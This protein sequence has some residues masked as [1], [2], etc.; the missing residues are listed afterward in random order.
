MGEARRRKLAGTSGLRPDTRRYIWG[1]GRGMR[2][3]IIVPIEPRGGNSF[4]LADYGEFREL[5]G[6]VGLDHGRYCFTLRTSQQQSEIA[7]IVLRAMQN[8]DEDDMLVIRGHAT[9]TIETG[10]SGESY[11]IISGTVLDVDQALDETL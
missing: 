10:D 1:I 3:L 8:S 9:E 2:T 7:G 11:R 6:I 4:S 5:T